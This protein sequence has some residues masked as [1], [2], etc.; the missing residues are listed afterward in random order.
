[1]TNGVAWPL[2]GHDAAEASVI[3]AMDSRRMHHA[4]L[5]E[6]PSGIGKARLAR[7]F[8]ATLLGAKAMSPNRLDVSREDPIV[9]K[10]L[11]GAHPDFRWVSRRPNEKGK[12]PLFIPVDQVREDLVSFFTLKPALGG[13]RVCVVDALDELNASGANAL[14]K[15]LEEPP[16]HCVLILIYHGQRALLATIRSRCRRLRMMTLG[17]E[18]L[19]AALSGAS[20]TVAAR[21]KGFAAGRPGRAIAFSDP[22]ALAGLAAAETLLGHLDRGPLREAPSIFASAAKSDASF[23]AFTSGLLDGLGTRAFDQPALADAWLWVTRLLDHASRDA[24]D[25]GQTTAKLVSG[26]QEHYRTA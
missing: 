11:A 4:W 10:M 12:L 23:S 24:M 9:E 19:E 25:R 20:E 16:S 3:A 2:F 5:L 15:S 14:L 17:P 1:M 22:E 21:A 18:D 6:G 13:R 26:L 7:R 8:A